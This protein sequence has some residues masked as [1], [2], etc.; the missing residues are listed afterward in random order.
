MTPKNDLN[1]FRVI[2]ATLTTMASALR[3]KKINT[4][5][6]YLYLLIKSYANYKTGEVEIAA[7]R[8]SEIAGLST[9]TI[10]RSISNLVKNEYLRNKSRNGQVNQYH[11]VEHVPLVVDG[12]PKLAKWEY[13][14]ATE[15]KVRDEIKKYL[16]GGELSSDVSVSIENMTINFYNNVVNINISHDVDLTKEE[17]DSILNALQNPKTPPNF[18]KK[19]TELYPQLKSEPG[20]I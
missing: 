14:P 17:M 1:W 8:L 2:R 15:T 6:I 4:T 11:L 20:Q 13:A 3:Q 9:A 16:A 19:L 18:R 12:E 5:D 7:P 10:K